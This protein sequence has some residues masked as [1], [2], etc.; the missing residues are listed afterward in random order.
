MDE[1]VLLPP[2]CSGSGPDLCS[3]TEHSKCDYTIRSTLEVLTSRPGLGVAS[4]E[5]GACP[6]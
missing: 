3:G 6:L 1:C 5:A 4:F 2:N